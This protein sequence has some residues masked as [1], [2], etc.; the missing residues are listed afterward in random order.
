[1]TAFEHAPV[2]VT[3]PISLNFIY[4]YLISLWLAHQIIYATWHLFSSLFKALRTSN[5]RLQM[6]ISANGSLFAQLWKPLKSTH[7]NWSKQVVAPNLVVSMSRWLFHKPW[8]INHCALQDY[9]SKLLSSR[10][11][12]PIKAKR[13]LSS[14]LVQPRGVL[15]WWTHAQC[16][17]SVMSSH[18]P[19]LYQ[20]AYTLPLNSMGTW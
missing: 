3:L 9:C 15:P 8:E 20:I 11:K 10:W 1:M 7:V 6:L 14:Q 17:L 12:P 16:N 5:D 4:T 13:P 19:G 2:F 18:S